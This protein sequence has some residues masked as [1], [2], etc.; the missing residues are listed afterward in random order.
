MSPNQSTSTAE[1]GKSVISY[2][3]PTAIID[4]THQEQQS[5]AARKRHACDHLLRF[6]LESPVGSFYLFHSHF[7]FASLTN[8]PPAERL[9]DSLSCV[10]TFVILDLSFKQLM[11]LSIGIKTVISN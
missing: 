2:H 10:N 6:A 5:V 3:N 8:L 4:K 7:R 1:R 9:F 11:Y